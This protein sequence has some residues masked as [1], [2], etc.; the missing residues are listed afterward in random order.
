MFKAFLIYEIDK[1]DINQPE[2]HTS[3]P[4]HYLL[5]HGRLSADSLLGLI[6]AGNGDI[7][8]GDEHGSTP[9]HYLCG[10][11]ASDEDTILQVI[12]KRNGEMNKRDDNGITPFHCLCKRLLTIRPIQCL[13]T[14]VKG[15]INQA[16][17]YGNTPFHYLCRREGIDMTD[18]QL[19]LKEIT[20]ADARKQNNLGHSPFDYI[21]QGKSL[22]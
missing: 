9:L 2:K 5:D 16:D 4:L 20:T 8:K 7:N 22:L 21:Q 14:E 18:V 13:I 12:K 10:N 3:T 19:Q 11:E 15:D 6:T 17:Q 1:G